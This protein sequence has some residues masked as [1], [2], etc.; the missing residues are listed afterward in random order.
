VSAHAAFRSELTD[1]DFDRLRVLIQREL[2]VQVPPIKRAMIEGRLGR[3]MRETGA[4]SV[5]E[6]CAALLDRREGDPE[7]VHFLDAVTVNVTS[8]FREPQQLDRLAQKL[9]AIS[10]GARAEQREVRVWSAACSRGHE[11][12]TLAMMLSELAPA[13]RFTIFGTDI[14]TRVLADAISAVYP[15]PDLDAVPAPL[16]ARYFLRSRRGEA[17]VRVAPELRQRVHFGRL[18]LMGPSFAMES[19]FDVAL[20][21]NVLIYFDSATQRAVASRVL[22]H[23]R[24]GGLLCVGLSESL[25]GHGLPATALGLGIYQKTGPAPGAGDGGKR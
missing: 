19:G 6:Y 23:V 9:V 16:R 14:S 2:G 1:A 24:P 21:R 12:W 7:L 11:P 8:F 17:V 10:A 15:E 25:H 3:R 20:L 5:A 22:G 18:N 4:T 13:P